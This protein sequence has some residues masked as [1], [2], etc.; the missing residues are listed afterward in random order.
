MLLNVQ[1]RT[2]GASRF[3]L[4]RHSQLF[5]GT[6]LQHKQVQ[7]L[8]AKDSFPAVNS[9]RAAGLL[10]SILVSYTMIL[11]QASAYITSKLQY[12]WQERDTCDRSWSSL[13]WQS[14]LLQSVKVEHLRPWVFGTVEIVCNRS[15]H[16]GVKSR[17]PSSS[18][19]VGITE[20][21]NDH[22]KSVYSPGLVAWRSMGRIWCTAQ[23]ANIAH[24]R[25]PFPFL[26]CLPHSYPVTDCNNQPAIFEAS[27]LLFH[28]EFECNEAS[29]PAFCNTVGRIS[30]LRLTILGNEGEAQPQLGKMMEGENGKKVQDCSRKCIATCLRCTSVKRNTW[31]KVS[32]K[33]KKHLLRPCWLQL[34]TEEKNKELCAGFLA[35]LAQ[36]VKHTLVGFQSI[37]YFGIEGCINLLSM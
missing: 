27:V 1:Y 16:N 22:T 36:F 8:R 25:C 17:A 35:C 24:N 13:V 19:V 37:H 7:S 12:S 5:R 28:Q 11:L 2:G 15:N 30:I 20:S 4:A 18:T 23:P 3:E 26:K 29:I 10:A 32:P 14:S 9:A 21:Q 34:Q 31:H 6:R 33:T